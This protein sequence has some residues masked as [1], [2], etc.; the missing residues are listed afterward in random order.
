MKDSLIPANRKLDTLGLLCPIPIAK[1]A[2]AV[3]MMRVGEILEVLSDDLGILI[4]L[5]A[6]CMSTGHS[7]IGVEEEAEQIVSY[8]RKEA[9]RGKFAGK[10]D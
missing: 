4:D 10:G 7:L 6:W 1:T 5:P 8:V 9:G 3:K 2:E